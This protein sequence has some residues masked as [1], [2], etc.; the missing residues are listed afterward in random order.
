LARPEDTA[1]L[2]QSQEVVVD[3]LYDVGRENQIEASIRKWQRA[4]IAQVN[5]TE[6][7]L[8]TIPDRLWAPVNPPYSSEAEIAQHA[9]I[10]AGPRADV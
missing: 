7:L 2:A 5:S 6:P 1:E 9:E 10:A 8:G 3:M 4:Y